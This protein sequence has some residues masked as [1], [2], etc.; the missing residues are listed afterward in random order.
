M[1]IIVRPIRIEV[2]EGDQNGITSIEYFCFLALADRPDDEFLG[3]LR[4]YGVNCSPDIYKSREVR[5]NALK[6]LLDFV[7]E[8]TSYK[9]KRQEEIDIRLP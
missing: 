8:Y 4:H 2:L 3:G 1:N 6:S 5:D 9:I 7:R